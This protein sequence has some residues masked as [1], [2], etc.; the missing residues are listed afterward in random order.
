[1]FVQTQSQLRLTVEQIIAAIL[2]L[3]SDEKNS[4]RLFVPS[5]LEPSEE[6]YLPTSSEN[7][8]F[9][10]RQDDDINLARLTSNEQNPNETRANDSSE[11][12]SYKARSWSDFVNNIDEFAV[13]IGIEDL[14]V[15]HDHYLYGLP[16]Q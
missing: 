9:S 15:N 16:K 7:A 8:Q 3:S 1:M 11:S 5:L 13:D 4:L 6:D 10:E 2:L 14:A 12:Y